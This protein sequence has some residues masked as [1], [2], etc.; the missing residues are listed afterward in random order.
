MSEREVS[1]LLI[2]FI[3]TLHETDTGQ[4]EDEKKKLEQQFKVDFC[5]YFLD[6]GLIFYFLLKMLFKYTAIFVCFGTGESLSLS[7]SQIVILVIYDC[8]E[9]V[10]D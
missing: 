8:I 5:T 9:I 4:R 3:R 2:S 10:Y 7:I 6:N 1:G